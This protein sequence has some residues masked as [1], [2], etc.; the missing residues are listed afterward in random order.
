MYLETKNVYEKG[1]AQG[2][3][4]T[5]RCY[6]TWVQHT[7]ATSLIKCFEAHRLGD[8]MDLTLYSGT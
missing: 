4:K 7:A 3:G 8:S 1:L 2:Y 5:M 6:R